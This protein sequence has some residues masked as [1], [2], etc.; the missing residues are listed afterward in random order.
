MY[1]NRT[2]GSFRM[3]RAFFFY[4]SIN[5]LVSQILRVPI[6]ILSY[7]RVAVLIDSTAL[8]SSLYDSQAK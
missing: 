5:P 1:G 4:F 7:K 3:D 2:E 8:R 6:Y